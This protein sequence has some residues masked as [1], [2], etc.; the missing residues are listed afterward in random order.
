MKFPLT[1]ALALAAMS[2]ALPAAA[3]MYKWVDASGRVQYSDNPPAGVKTE[4]IKSRVSSVQ[5]PAPT[6]PESTADKEQAFRKRQADAE[7]AAKKQD[8][9]A[10]QSREACGNARSRLAGLE[11]G[12]R[13]VRFDPSGERHYLDDQQIA[14]EKTQAQQDA[15]K[16][17]N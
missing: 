9:L 4:A 3:Q 14:Q 16:Y 1:A 13:Q 10:Q 8:Q 15:A 2:V 5:A 7:G 11:A 17:C 6:Q 12:G